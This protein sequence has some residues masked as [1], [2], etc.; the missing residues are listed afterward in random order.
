[1]AAGLKLQRICPLICE[2]GFRADG[3]KC[4]KI[5]CRKGYELNDEGTCEKIE[6]KKPIAKRDEPKA[7]RERAER[8]AVPAKPQAS[9]HRLLPRRVQA[10]QTRQ[11]QATTADGQKEA[12]NLYKPSVWPDHPPLFRAGRGCRAPSLMRNPSFPGL[13]SA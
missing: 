1:M 8:K 2:T 4:V 13:R 3:D 11:D 6:V 12:C 9:G 7:K 10:G 5:I